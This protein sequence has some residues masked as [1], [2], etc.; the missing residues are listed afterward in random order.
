MTYVCVCVKTRRRPTL[1]DSIKSVRHMVIVGIFARNPH[2]ICCWSVTVVVRSCSTFVALRRHGPVPDDCGE[3]TWR[4]VAEVMSCVTRTARAYC[5]TCALVIGY[6]RRLLDGSPIEFARLRRSRI[7]YRKKKIHTKRI[8]E[9]YFCRSLITSRPVVFR[10][11]DRFRASIFS[12]AVNA[13]IY[14]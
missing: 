1:A 13:V 12:F 7:I 5:A 6:G 10:T 4:Y 9:G 3:Y 11:Y 2:D 14:E 8:S